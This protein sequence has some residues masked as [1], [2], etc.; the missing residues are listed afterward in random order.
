M[1]VINA[2][3]TEEAWMLA[4]YI[5]G[6][7]ALIGGIYALSRSNWR[8]ALIGSICAIPTG[9]GVL[10]TIFVVLSRKEFK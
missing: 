5:L 10:S 2:G 4:L 1:D 6:A 3:K 8:L 9:I 7:I